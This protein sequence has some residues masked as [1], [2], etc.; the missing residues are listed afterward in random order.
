MGFG[1]RLVRKVANLVMHIPRKQYYARY[2]KALKNDAPTIIASDCF[3]GLVY[4]NL[5]LQF[6]SP[7]VNLYFPKEDFLL[8]VSNLKEYLAAE[9]TETEDPSVTFPV[10]ALEHNG[11]KVR[12]YFMHYPDFPSAKAKWEERTR[13]VDFTNLCIIQTLSSATAEDIRAFD[14]LPYPNKLLITGEDPVGSANVRTH[15]VYRKADYR[16]GEILKYKSLFALKRYMD[17]ID[18]V[19]FLNGMSRR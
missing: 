3:G 4:H 13:R 18:Y 2:R 14:A 8:F 17:E 9:L 1:Y 12:I 19:G 15:P 7:T 5:G 6:R 11:Q 16:P 10:G